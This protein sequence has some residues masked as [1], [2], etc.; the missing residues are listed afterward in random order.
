[1]TAS[2]VRSCS[3]MPAGVVAATGP[4]SGAGAGAGAAVVVVVGA[5]VVVGA[6]VV[7]AARSSSP[8]P[9]LHATRRSTS[10]T[11]AALRTVDPVDAAVQ[12]QRVQLAGG[13]LAEGDDEALGCGRAEVGVIRRAVVPAKGLDVAAVGV[14]EQVDAAERGDLRPAVHEAADDGLTLLVAVLVHGRQRAGR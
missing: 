3:A 11:A 1:M 9:P 10:A 7:G 8:P 4:R 5:T 13:V 6:L 14:G 2:D 12:R